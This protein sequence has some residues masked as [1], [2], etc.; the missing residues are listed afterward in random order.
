MIHHGRLGCN[1][2]TTRFLPLFEVTDN[3]G[4]VP[5]CAHLQRL[6]RVVVNDR[7]RVMR[8]TRGR[9]I[10]GHHIMPRVF[11]K[12]VQVVVRRLL[13]LPEYR[14]LVVQTLDGFSLDGHRRWSEHRIVQILNDLF[15]TQELI[16]QLTNFMTLQIGVWSAG[17]IHIAN[18]SGTIY[19]LL[20]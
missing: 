6:E 9:H 14:L 2:E 15:P 1:K 16:N 7:C 20:G 5:I 3:N 17:I 19:S 13:S 18:A 10:L 4:S 11:F 12:V 8:L